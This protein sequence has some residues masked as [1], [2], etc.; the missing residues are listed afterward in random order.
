MYEQIQ[1]KTVPEIPKLLYSRFSN[2][3]WDC[4]DCIDGIVYIMKMFAD[5]TNGVE[6]NQ[7]QTVNH[8]RKI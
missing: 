6:L 7:Y 2:T 5:D 3:L 8:C 1:E 4:W